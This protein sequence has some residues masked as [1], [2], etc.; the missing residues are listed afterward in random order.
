[1]RRACVLVVIFLFAVQGCD[2]SI[3]RN[4]TVADGKRRSEGAHSINGKI[5]V[6]QGCDIRGASRTINGSID[7][8]PDSRVRSLQT[9][10]GHVE[11]D[12]NVH[13]RGDIQTINGRVHCGAGTRIEGDIE[14]INGRLSL[15]STSVRGG[16]QTC[17]G[18]VVLDHHSEIQKDIIVKGPKEHKRRHR[19]RQLDI[20]LSNGS[21][22]MGDILVKDPDRKVTVYLSS[23]AQVLGRVQNAQIV[24]EP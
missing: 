1:M 16:L 17:N 21:R 7:I 4:L 6:G 9:I 24:N 19:P 14:T 15:D 3:N 18:Q 10:N 12:A 23:G 5:R 2:L 13:V 8:G 11:I 22:V 20:R